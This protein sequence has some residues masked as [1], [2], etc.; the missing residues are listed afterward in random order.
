MT[1]SIAGVPARGRSLSPAMTTAGIWLAGAA[2]MVLLPQLFSTGA[3][4]T[5]LCLMGIMIIFALAYNM[6]LGQT[7]MLSFGHAVYYGLGGFFAAHAM[8]IISGDKLP[9]P[10]AAVPVVGA[11]T[12]FVFG[13]VFGAASTRR[14]G[15][16]F[17]MISL[18]IV[19]LVAALAL[20]MTGFFG[21]EQGVS[22][23]RTKALA[24]FGWK[25]GPQIQVYY[26]IAAWCFVSMAAMYFITRTPFGRMCLAVRE[27]PER[28][29]FVG[30][31]TQGIRF[32][33]FCLSGAFAGIAGALAAINFEIASNS[34]L[35]AQQSGA[36]LLMAYIGGAGHF[37]GPIVGAILITLLQSSL[38]DITGAWQLYFGIMFIL[39]VMFIPGGLAGLITMHGPLARAGLL[40]RLVAPYARAL[41]PG[42]LLV[43]GG[44]LVIELTYKLTVERAK[45]TVLEL[46]PLSLDARTALPWIAALVL[47]A[48]GA[49]ALRRMGPGIAEAVSA[50]RAEALA[51]IGA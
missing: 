47:L 18:G 13:I 7:G 15:T 19:E 39:V 6:L 33:A 37:A 51:R 29:S 20:V 2:V 23:N 48:A 42:L 32:I 9:I 11:I 21:G 16:A 44:S 35:G 22:F 17:A 26:L 5:K 8:M 3:S 41:V 49:W 31:S 12:G 45:T 46:G 28:A 38:S 34:M 30:Y 14:A 43:V 25:F 40:P 50:V 24:L 4:L 27:N 1:Q 36:V 10:L